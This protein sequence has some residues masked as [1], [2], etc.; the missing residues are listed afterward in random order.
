M[1]KV[2][3]NSLPLTCIFTE[4]GVSLYGEKKEAFYPYGCM[5]SIYT[6]ILGTLEI[7]FGFSEVSFRPEKADRP[8]LR[9]AIKEARA[10]VKTAEPDEAKVYSRCSKVPGDLPR[11]EQLKQFKYLLSTG[12]ISKGYFDL[13][14][15]L[16]TEE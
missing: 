16:L 8:A 2:F 4:E 12:T 11:E 1:K 10:L 15:R 13:K 3:K 7:R 5:D 9:A 6:G 14:K